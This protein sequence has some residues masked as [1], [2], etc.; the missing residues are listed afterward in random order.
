M[1]VVATLHCEHVDPSGTPCGKVSMSCG[2]VQQAVD[3]ARKNQWYAADPAIVHADRGD[4]CAK[5]SGDPTR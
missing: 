3:W 2:S 4:R 1:S 5:H